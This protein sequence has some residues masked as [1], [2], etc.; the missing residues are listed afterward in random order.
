MIAAIA[1]SDLAKGVA[2]MIAGL[3]AS[4]AVA[5]LASYLAWRRDPDRA[6]AA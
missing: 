5:T 3:V 4:I 2:V 6:R 1:F